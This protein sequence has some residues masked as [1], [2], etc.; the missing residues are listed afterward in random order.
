M[1]LSQNSTRDPFEL[2]TFGFRGGRS[3]VIWVLH[4]VSPSSGLLCTLA[5]L[6]AFAFPTSAPPCPLPHKCCCILSF[7]LLLPCRVFLKHSSSLCLSDVHHPA[8]ETSDSKFL[9]PWRAIETHTTGHRCFSDTVSFE[10]IECWLLYSWY[11]LRCFIPREQM[12]KGIEGSLGAGS[13]CR[14]KAAFMEQEWE[15]VQG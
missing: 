8:Q 15:E 7:S 6:P 4:S 10:L 12:M 11:P 13:F 14:R 2:E 5:P 9:L 1:A 3:K